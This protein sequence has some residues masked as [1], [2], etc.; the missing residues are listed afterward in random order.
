MQ[1]KP[2]GMD[3]RAG[4]DAE[5]KQ[6]QM[7]AP[8]HTESDAMPMTRIEPHWPPRPTIRKLMEGRPAGADDGGISP[9]RYLGRPPQSAYKTEDRAQRGGTR[10]GAPYRALAQRGAAERTRCRRAA[11]RGRARYRRRG[12]GGKGRG[13][14]E[15]WRVTPGR[16]AHLACPGTAKQHA[17]RGREDQRRTKRGAVIR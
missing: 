9:T 4:R 11:V 10:E 15:E 5:G 2:R 17:P 8:H 7:G 12:K 6:R 16:G 14:R 1:A 13:E 3:A